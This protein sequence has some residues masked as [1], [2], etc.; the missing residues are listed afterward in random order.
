MH[1]MARVY[2][3]LVVFFR[4]GIGL[5]SSTGVGVIG[6]P[7]F[8]WYSMTNDHFAYRTRPSREDVLAGSYFDV[9]ASSV[10]H[11]L[12][13]SMSSMGAG[14]CFSNA[15]MSERDVPSREPPLRTRRTLCQDGRVFEVSNAFSAST[16][17]V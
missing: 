9:K 11:P 17:S 15:G 3:S 5:P 14:K 2:P 7:P 13:A 4:G 8:V 10:Y 1:H 6:T 12:K 16:R